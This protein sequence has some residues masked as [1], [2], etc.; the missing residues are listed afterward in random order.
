MNPRNFSLARR[1]F[2]TIAVSGMAFVVTAA[3]AVD[4]AIL[5]QISAAY[6]VSE[7]VASLCTGLFL[8]GFAAGALFCGPLSELFGRNAV[9]ACSLL[10]FM[11][12]VMAS[13]LAP[14][15][16]SLLIFRF[17][18]GVFGSPP[19]TCAGG[20]IADL[21]SPMEKTLVFPLFSILA[22]GGPTLG[23]VIASYMGQG[24]LSWRWTS[25][26]VLIMSG[27]ILALILLVQPET[28]GPV[29][30]RWK[31]YHLRSL[32]SDQTYKAQM[33]INHTPL[34]SRVIK[35]CVNQF[36][37]PFKEP[38]V[39]L[40]SLYLTV[41]YIILFTFFDG[42]S[43][44]FTDVYHTSQGLT[45]IIWAASYVGITLAVIPILWIY[46]HKHR[47]IVKA[48]NVYQIAENGGYD[49]PPSGMHFEKP[50]DTSPPEA[51]LW[52]AMIGAPT[53]PISLFWMGWTDY[54]SLHETKYSSEKAKSI[55][56]DFFLCSLIFRSG[57]QL[58][59][60][61]FL[62]LDLYAYLSRATCISLMYTR[63]M[64]LLLSV[65]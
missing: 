64:Q 41:V 25:W 14:N 33:D 35:A 19:L 32:T 1:T 18:C 36:T 17:I 21:W 39:L 20:T 8:I 63:Y 38:I 60:P 58:S 52:Y 9:Y 22:F 44:I 65:S 11:L 28:Y 26:I 55:F 5:P 12:F 50:E 23:P 42:Y 40:L 47:M 2:A 31:A 56:N 4:S 3:S 53:I 54:V 59:P 10:L 43:F 16:G 49:Q 29:L 27:L 62:D 15:I 30:L 57:P 6:H 45:N 48:R 7:V 61:P 46:L 24:T 51:R 13:G 34:F 37:I